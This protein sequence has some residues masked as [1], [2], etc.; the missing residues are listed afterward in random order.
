MK[1]WMIVNIYQAYDAVIG[2]GDMRLQDR[3]KPSVIYCEKGEV[4]AEMFRLKGKVPD[5]EFVLLESVAI[6]RP[7][8]DG[9]ALKLDEVE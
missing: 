1:F 2:Y 5:G 3:N 4:E 7:I 6:V 8:A 9:L